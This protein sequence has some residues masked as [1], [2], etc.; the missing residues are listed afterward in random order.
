MQIKIRIVSRKEAEERR[1]EEKIAYSQIAPYIIQ[2]QTIPEIQ[3]KIFLR[4]YA[5]ALG[6]P[7]GKIY[8]LIG[9]SAQEALQEQENAIIAE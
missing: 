4:S 7:K 5:E 6:I 2:D 3:K 1:S 9:T 8:V